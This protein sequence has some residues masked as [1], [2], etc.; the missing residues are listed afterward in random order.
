MWLNDVSS[1]YDYIQVS[2]MGKEKM[3][4]IQILAQ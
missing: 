2:V 3:H 1:L 4:N